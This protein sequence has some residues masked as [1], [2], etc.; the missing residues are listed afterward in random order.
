MQKELREIDFPK[1]IQLASTQGFHFKQKRLFLRIKAH[2]FY[3]GWDKVKVKRS[4]PYCY[5]EA[6]L[7]LKEHAFLAKRTNL[8]RNVVEIQKMH[9]I[10]S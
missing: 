5:G 10:V 2:Y 7:S 1:Q 6:P 8:N 9:H 3:K 4:K